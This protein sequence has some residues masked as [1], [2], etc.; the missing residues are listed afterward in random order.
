[1]QRSTNI[2]RCTPNELGGQTMCARTQLQRTTGRVARG[3][4]LIEL[5]LVMVI[6]AIL[7][8]VV[9]PRFSGKSEQARQTKAIADIAT[10]KGALQRFEIENGRYPTTEEGL[11]ALVEKPAGLDSWKSAYIDQLMNDPWGQPYI[12]RCPGSN[13][14]DFDLLSGGKDLHEG[15]GDDVQ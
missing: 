11:Q 8:A 5:M 15:G 10:L 4:T 12:Y 7:A 2:A 6:L 14:K 13:G 1:M 3:F 9:V